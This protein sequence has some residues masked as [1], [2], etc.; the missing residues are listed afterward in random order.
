MHTMMAKM[1]KDVMERIET[2][3]EKAQAEFVAMAL[4]IDATLSH[5]TYHATKEELQAI[6][7]ADQSGIA[8]DEEVEAA[9][10]TFRRS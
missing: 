10:A 9:F 8:S 3:P 2:W 1:L 6:D 4:D 7:E 5:G